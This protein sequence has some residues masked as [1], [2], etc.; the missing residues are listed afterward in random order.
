M[1]KER[2]VFRIDT[3]R[4]H[5]WQVRIRRNGEWHRKFFSDSKFDSREAAFEAA[6]A[7]RDEMIEELPDL[8]G[9][10]DDEASHLHT[11]EI[12]ERR[13]HAVTRTGV[14]GLGFTM[15]TYSRAT[16]DK[17][18]YVNAYWTEDG[19][20]RSTSYSIIK[21]GLAGALKRT[22][23]VLA[24]HTDHELTVEEMIDTAEP[25]L[26]DLLEQADVRESDWQT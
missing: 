5:G 1:R 24:A 23:E 14:K 2:N 8:P 6:V 9:D 3:G 11:E 13:W 7:H 10:P 19:T 17:R 12:D 18:P 21:H 25:A 16:D 20:R 26:L 15:K 4:T 22:A